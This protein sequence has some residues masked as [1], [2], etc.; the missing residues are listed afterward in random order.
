MS[1]ERLRPT[2]CTCDPAFEQTVRGKHAFTRP[3]RCP[4]CDARVYFLLHDG[5]SV[6]LD[7]PLAWPWPVHR[8]FADGAGAQ[9][10]VGAFHGRPRGALTVCRVAVVQTL[11]KTGERAVVLEHLDERISVW[12]TTDM[13][14]DPAP[15]SLASISE[16]T[17]DFTQGA[18]V[19][20][21][22][23]PCDRCRWCQGWFTRKELPAHEAAE[24]GA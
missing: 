2:G 13:A 10:F 7:A 9:E 5:G 14:F 11:P 12:K 20:S 17:G 8:C 6:W 22:T 16:A 4:Q 18:I 24:R 21:L 19:H 15:A 3:S 23:G 1:G